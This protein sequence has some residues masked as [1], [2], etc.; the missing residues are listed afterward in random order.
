MIAAEEGNLTAVNYFIK[1]NLPVT[2]R[3]GEEYAIDLAYKNKHF[4]VVLALL[5]ANSPFPKDFN[6]NSA[7]DGVKE[8]VNLMKDM[9]EAINKDDKE[10][11][12]QIVE[13]NPNLR[14]FF[15][16]ESET[17]I[18]AALRQ[19]ACESYEVLMLKNLSYKSAEDYKS[20]LESLSLEDRE[21]IRQINFKHT[22]G[23][24]AKHIIALMGKS[25]VVKIKNGKSQSELL[26]YVHRA[27]DVLDSIP[28]L[29]RVLKLSA[30]LENLQLVFDFENEILQFLDPTAGPFDNASF[31]HNCG[32]IAIAAKKFLD[33]ETEHIA[34]GA[35]AHELCHLTML[36][37]HQN[38]AKPY[39]KNDTKSEGEFEEISK[40]CDEN[41]EK[42]IITK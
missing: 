2:F 1:S 12:Q 13:E 16:L 34:I 18:G 4:E 10:K 32:Q 36:L 33:P 30:T 26:N 38:M 7:S 39:A 42:E 21:K 22:R 35:L 14:Y 23:F 28:R 20:I 15:N 19:V 37:L 29:R 9:H 3:I 25:T 31:Y 24:G 41:K 17:A 5:E 11:V 8:F 40:F 6:V 27:F